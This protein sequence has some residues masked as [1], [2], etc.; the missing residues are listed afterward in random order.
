MGLS[1]SQVIVEKLSILKFIYVHD[2]KNFIARVAFGAAFLNPSEA[3]GYWVPDI[4]AGIVTI[5]I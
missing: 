3:G 1:F 5:W 4:S 2:G